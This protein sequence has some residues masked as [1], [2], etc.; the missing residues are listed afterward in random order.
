MSYLLEIFPL[1]K[2]GRNDL[3]RLWDAI[4]IAMA[5]LFMAVFLVIH[6]TISVPKAIQEDRKKLQAEV[7]MWSEV[8]R[9]R[10]R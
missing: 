10:N 5:F 2:A 7:E 8:W 4:A 1:R 9:G 3:L 6:F